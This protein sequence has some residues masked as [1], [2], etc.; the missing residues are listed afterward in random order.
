MNA[1]DHP[2]VAEIFE[3]MSAT[4]PTTSLG[5][6]Y[7]TLET[8]KE[9]G[10]VIELQFRNGS[11]R[12]DGVHRTTH[13]HVICTRCGRIEDMEIEGLRVMEAQAAENTGYQVHSFHLEFYGLCT[14]CQ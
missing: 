3:R 9:M 10:E 2:T 14:H 12:Y 7:R 1:N 13:P 5:T 6:V 8:L 4:C 11:N